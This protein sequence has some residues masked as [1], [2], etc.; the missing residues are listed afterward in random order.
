MNDKNYS[1]NYIANLIK[2]IKADNNKAFEELYFI[3]SQRL[4]YFSLKFLKSNNY[5]E[6]FVQEMFVKIWEM[7][8]KLNEEKSFNAFLFT[9]AKNTLLNRYQKKIHE[10]NYLRHLKK[11]METSESKDE[12]QLIMD[13]IKLAVDK[14]L[15][16]LPP[17]QYKVFTLSRFDK[18]TYRQIAEQLHISEKTVEAH[19]RLALKFIRKYLDKILLI[20][21]IFKFLFN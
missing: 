18:L 11:H 21:L 12:N 6:E 17:Q 1:H 7:R 5:A 2:Q 8:H 15:A 19:M 13:D 4:Y 3:F 14:C 16:K 10:E 20:L 9:V